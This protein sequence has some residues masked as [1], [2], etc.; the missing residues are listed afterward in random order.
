MAVLANASLA[1]ALSALTPRVQP[2][3]VQVGAQ[4]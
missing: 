4:N 2:V 3:G 1:L